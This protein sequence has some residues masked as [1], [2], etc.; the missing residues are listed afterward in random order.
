M[1]KR[2]SLVD[3]RDRVGDSG[4]GDPADEPEGVQ[5]FSLNDCSARQAVA[6]LAVK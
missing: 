4:E 1:P 6:V 2:G 5:L 3:R